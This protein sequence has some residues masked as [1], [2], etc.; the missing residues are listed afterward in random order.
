MTSTL[1]PSLSPQPGHE[2]REGPERHQTTH[3]NNT[4]ITTKA[5]Q[6]KGQQERKWIAVGGALSLVNSVR[7]MS[8]LTFLKLSSRQVTWDL[9]LLF[10]LCLRLSESPDALRIF[11]LSLAM[12]PRHDSGAAASGGGGRVVVEQPQTVSLSD[13]SSVSAC[14][15]AASLASQI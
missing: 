3:S 2:K 15:S 4:L 8:H 12:T 7:S 11:A 1:P 6:R 9:S 5:S 13:H 14:R 10:L